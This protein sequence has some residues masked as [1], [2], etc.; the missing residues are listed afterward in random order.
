MKEQKKLGNLHFP[1]GFLN[2]MTFNDPGL[3]ARVQ[4]PRGDGSPLLNA[5]EKEHFKGSGR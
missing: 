4:D 3:P 5:V 2:K 1:L